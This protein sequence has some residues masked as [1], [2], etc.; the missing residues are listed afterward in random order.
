MMPPITSMV[1]SN[2]PSRWA[3]DCA[4]R[5][6]GCGVEFNLFRL[7]RILSGASPE[8]IANLPIDSFTIWNL[9][10]RPFYEENFLLRCIGIFSPFRFVWQFFLKDRKRQ[11][12]D[13]CYIGTCR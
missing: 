13:A 1:A 9:L 12:A 3:R 6:F 2:K 5:E 10:W 8:R 4:V 11:Y 7:E